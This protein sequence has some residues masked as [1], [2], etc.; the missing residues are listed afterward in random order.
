MNSPEDVVWALISAW[1]IK[2]ATSLLSVSHSCIRRVT[3]YYLLR[4]ERERT[5]AA[6]GEGE[7]GTAALCSKGKSLSAMEL[8]KAI[9]TYS[10]SA[11]K[12]ITAR[13]TPGRY[14]QGWTGLTEYN[15]SFSPS[16]ARSS[17]CKYSQA[18]AKSMCDWWSWCGGDRNRL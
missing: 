3:D 6:S 2:M 14:V 9:Y 17:G 18:S 5:L 16:L 11:C 8:Y 12:F 15:L 1:E 4:R 7:A 10:T 13:R